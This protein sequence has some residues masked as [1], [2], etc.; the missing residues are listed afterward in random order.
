MISFLFLYFL[1]Y[2]KMNQA[3]YNIGYFARMSLMTSKESETVET[4]E[5]QQCYKSIVKFTEQDIPMCM[6]CDDP[7]PIEYLNGEKSDQMWCECISAGGWFCPNHSPTT[8]CETADWWDECPMCKPTD[9][10]K[11]YR[12]ANK[13]KIKQQKKQYYIFKCSWGGDKRHHNNLLEID[14]NLFN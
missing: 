14:M 9:K 2:F 8:C 12:T 4:V 11:A 3:N 5:Y 10:V 13:D 1:Y 6:K 7:V